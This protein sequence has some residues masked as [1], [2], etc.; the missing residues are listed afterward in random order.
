[1]ATYHALY[2][3]GGAYFWRSFEADDLSHA[4]DQAVDA[5]EVDEELI[6]ILRVK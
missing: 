4:L 6:S 2:E 1:M 3:L 5:T